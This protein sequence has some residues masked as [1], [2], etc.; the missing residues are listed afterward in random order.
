MGF[1]VGVKVFVVVEI[2]GCWCVVY[3][4]SYGVGLGFKGWRVVGRLWDCGVKV[5]GVGLILGFKGG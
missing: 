5:C 3:M 2:V 1:E 4:L